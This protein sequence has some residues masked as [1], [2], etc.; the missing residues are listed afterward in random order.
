MAEDLVLQDCV[1]TEKQ[2]KKQREIASRDQ[3]IA[4]DAVVVIVAL[5]GAA[6]H[7]RHH[8]HFDPEHYRGFTA[9]CQAIMK[10]HAGIVAAS[11]TL[12][13]L[14]NA[15]VDHAAV[16]WFSKDGIN[17][18]K[19]M[20]ELRESLLA[21]IRN[22]QPP[23]MHERHHLAAIGRNEFAAAHLLQLARRDVTI[24]DPVIRERLERENKALTDL[25]QML[26]VLLPD[27]GHE[28][29]TTRRFI[30]VNID[31]L[32]LLMNA[33]QQSQADAARKRSA[34]VLL[35]GT[36]DAQ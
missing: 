11:I 15:V 32:R 10:K 24:I 6:E 36:V 28:L 31:K 4:P 16:G 30:D 14:D 9:R 13:L 29:E 1:R 25:A 3:P 12:E 26:N 5:D 34:H 35:A 7:K 19:A 22:Y 27:Y 20:V 18:V 2:L 33:R 8:R 23:W 17:A 21:D